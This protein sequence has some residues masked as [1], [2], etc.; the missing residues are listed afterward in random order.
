MFFWVI[1][2]Y[3]HRTFQIQVLPATGFGW[4]GH[5]LMPALVLAMR[6]MAQLAQVTYISL[7]DVMRQ[8]YI[9]TAQAKGLAW[10]DVRNRHGLRNILI[11]ILT[12]LGTSLRYSLASL[13]IVE[14]FLT[15]KV[16]SDIIS[17]NQSW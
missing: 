9:R 4:D 2:I 10:R 11:P 1:N 15:G 13:T 16:W 8:D 12:T 6:P 5:L 17:S 14:L 7:T 3:I